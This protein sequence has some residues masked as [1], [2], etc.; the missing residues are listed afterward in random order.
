MRI[1]LTGVAGFIGSHFLE[2]FLKNGYEVVGIDNLKYGYKKYIDWA[3]QDYPK[4]TF[5]TLSIGDSEILN[6]IKEGDIVFHLAAIS[7]L[8]SNQENPAYSYTNNVVGTI[9]LLEAC[10]KKGCKHFIFASTSAV[11]ENSVKFP[12][13][14]YEDNKPDLIYSLGKLHAEQ[15]IQSYHSVYGLPYTILRFFNVYG[16]RQDALRTHPPLI[17]YLIH[18]FKNN[19]TPML[20]SDGNQKRDYVHVEDIEKLVDKLLK[21]GPLNTTFNVCSETTITVKEIVDVIK[22]Y[23][24]SNITPIYRD[25]CLLWEKS[26]QLWQGYYAFSKDRMK[27]EVEKYTIGSSNKTR[28]YLN[29]TATIDMREA[30]KVLYDIS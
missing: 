23:A 26:E 4:F 17:P 18:C 8:A 1:I 21:I 19:I 25:P 11:Y 16:S 13:T 20:H 9:N 14:E 27:S 10:R 29:W 12:L 22:E 28:E 2:Y 24:N 15:C 7:S 5:F 30:L 3:L 6:I